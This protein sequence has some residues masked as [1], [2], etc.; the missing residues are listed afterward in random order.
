M[1][2]SDCVLCCAHDAWQ[3]LFKYLL[4]HNIS[5][6]TLEPTFCFLHMVSIMPIARLIES[7]RQV[8]RA[9]HTVYIHNIILLFFY[10]SLV[11][12][13]PLLIGFIH[14]VAVWS[15]ATLRATAR[16]SSAAFAL[17]YVISKI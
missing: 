1:R 3:W 12:F 2:G 15:E 9:K 13:F 8:H 7:K 11:F 5:P 10:E 16:A 4:P 6:N 14:F 17:Y